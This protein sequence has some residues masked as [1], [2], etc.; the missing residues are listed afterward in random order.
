MFKTI[1]VGLLLLVSSMFV[2]AEGLSKELE[3]AVKAKCTEGCAVLSAEEIA[4]LNLAVEHLVNEAFQK[5][6]ASEKGSCRKLGNET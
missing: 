3:D 1:L 6:K 5:G 2:Q 4:Q